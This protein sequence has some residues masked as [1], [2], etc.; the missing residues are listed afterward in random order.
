MNDWKTKNN[1]LIKEFIFKDFNEALDFINK[2]ANEA[3]SLNHHP[4]IINTYSSV[5][6]ELWTHSENKVTELDHLLKEKIDLV[7]VT[8]IK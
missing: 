8:F 7:G 4:T 6:I 5:I 1:K 3:E 2:I